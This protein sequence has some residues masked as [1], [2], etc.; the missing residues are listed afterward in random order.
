MPDWKENIL[1]L[2]NDSLFW[3]SIWLSAGRPTQGGLFNVMKWCRNKYHFAVKQAK[4]K[5][6]YLESQLL[7]EA[8]IAG[9]AE[10]FKLMKNHLGSKSFG[11]DIPDTLEGKVTKDDILEKFKE[12][13]AIL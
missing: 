6:K 2:K 11:Q 3:H 4:R 12:C 7:G 1:P 5:A 10:F 8:A 9:N 13:Y